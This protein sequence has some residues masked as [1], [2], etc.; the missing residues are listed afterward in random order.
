MKEIPV[1]QYTALVDDEDY[2]RISRHCWYVSKRVHKGKVWIYAHTR[3][4]GT[5][6]RIKMHRMVMSAPRGVFVDHVNHNT[7]DNRK[8]NLRFCTASQNRQNACMSR[9]N[10]AGLKG[11][12]SPKNER[13]SYRACISIN[14]KQ[15]RWG[16]FSTPDE[17]HKDYLRRAKEV[18]GEFA[19]A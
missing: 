16:R 5:S 8:D 4:R 18:F 6:T 11:V 19:H 17:A 14:G 2:D 12:V 3:V 15:V 7:L 1:G 13:G 10:K 9:H